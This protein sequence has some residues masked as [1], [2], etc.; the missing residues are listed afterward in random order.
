MRVSV[1]ALCAL[2]AAAVAGAQGTVHATPD[3]EKLD[4]SLARG[5]DAAAQALLRS[6]QPEL[7][8]NERL[9]F[10]TIYVLVGRRRFPEAREQWNRLGGRL[11]E[12]LRTAPGSVDDTAL[13]RKV[14]EAFFVQGLLTARLGEKDEAMKLLARADGL[15]FP[16]LDSPLMLLAGDCLLELGEP[17]LATQAY[18]EMVKRAPANGAARR[19]LASALYASGRIAE[20]AVAVDE[21]LRLAPDLPRIL[22]LKGAVLFHQKRYAEARSFLE[23]EV[24]RDP[25]CIECLS[26]LAHVAYLEGDDE[27]CLS[28][29][30]KTEALDRDDPEASLVRGMIAYREGRYA[31]AV[32]RLTSVARQSPDSSQVQYQL[33]LAYRRIGDAAKAKEHLDAYTRLL[34]AE[35]ARTLGVRG[36]E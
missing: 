15:G 28:W 26:R 30:A 27:A 2:L 16:P 24:A 13:K 22:Y 14:A 17:V 36:S 20:A 1:L 31:D 10:D 32:E 11:Q 18:R 7:D 12:E 4:A 6:L 9:A 29:L 35:K 3:L 25:G 21:A 19:G 23:R 34:E 8:A 5:D 33:A